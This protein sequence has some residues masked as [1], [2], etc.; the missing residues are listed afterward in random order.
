[1]DKKEQLQWLL[2]NADKIEIMDIYPD[3]QDGTPT[4]LIKFANWDVAEMSPFKEG[5]ACIIFE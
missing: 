5:V 1:M 2:D 4:L 3:G